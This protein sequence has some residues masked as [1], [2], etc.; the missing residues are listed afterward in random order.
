MIDLIY[1]SSKYRNK[2]MM[3]DD[4]TC[5]DV[6]KVNK[7]VKYLLDIENLPLY[8]IRIDIFLLLSGI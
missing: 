2:E 3:L 1:F 6:G 8:K 5:L 7:A 4:P